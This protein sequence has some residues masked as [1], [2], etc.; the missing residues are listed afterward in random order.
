MRM[1]FCV[2]R[3]LPQVLERLEE[4][5]SSGQPQPCIFYEPSGLPEEGRRVV[6]GVWLREG[7]ARVHL[8]LPMTSHSHDG[9]IAIKMPFTHN[10]HHHHKTGVA[11]PCMKQDR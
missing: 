4:A 7:Q 3:R 11:A 6:G 5:T 8:T 10:P 2:H 9:I 1:S